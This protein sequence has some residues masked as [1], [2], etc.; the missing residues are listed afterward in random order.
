[1]NIKYVHLSIYK[2]L[3][4]ENNL[5]VMIG[6]RIMLNDYNELVFILNDVLK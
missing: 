6:L 2:E 4:H 5:I 3:Y 1:M